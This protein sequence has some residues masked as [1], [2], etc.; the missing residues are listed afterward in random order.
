M[1][2]PES[3][4]F[5]PHKISSEKHLATSQKP[6]TPDGTPDGSP[7]SL[8]YAYSILFPQ[9]YF[10]VNLTPV[11]PCPGALSQ[12]PPFGDGPHGVHGGTG[13]S[14]T[15]S[16]EFAVF[17][18]ELNP[19]SNCHKQPMFVRKSKVWEGL[20]CLKCSN[21]QSNGFFVEVYSC[22]NLVASQSYVS[23]R[24]NPLNQI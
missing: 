11:H 13:A 18:S 14:P 22:S 23:L 15:T 3:I 10:H 17:S 8:L 21:T 6:G 4:L 9:S 24:L 20:G 5:R 7:K 1:T 16:G 19:P 12:N 2:H